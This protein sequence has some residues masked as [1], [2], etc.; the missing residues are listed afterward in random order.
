MDLEGAGCC[1]M[2]DVAWQ[3]AARFA[4]NPRVFASHH[5]YNLY[6]DPLPRSPLFCAVRLFSGRSFDL[7]RL[8][9][10]ICN[11]QRSACTSIRSNALVVA[12][13]NNKANA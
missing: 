13:T 8:D 12:R 6:L 1:N 5:P 2:F 10:V 11:V 4:S 9:E 3:H 7:Q